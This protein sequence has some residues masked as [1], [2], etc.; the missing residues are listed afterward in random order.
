MHFAELTAIITALLMTHT[1]QGDGIPEP[2]L[3]M[4]GSVSNITGGNWVANQ[5][6][7]WQISF[8]KTNI[9]VTSKWVVVNSQPFYIAQVPFETRSI[10]GLTMTPNP[11]A[12]ELTVAASSYTRSPK[13]GTN[14]VQFANPAQTNFTF[15]SANRGSI[16]RIDLVTSI[17]STSETYE[18]WATRLFGRTDNRL[19]DPDRDGFSNYAEF[20]AGTDPQ[21]AES[22][23]EFINVKPIHG[24]GVT[25]EWSSVSNKR[26]SIERTDSLTKPFVALKTG[27]AS[28]PPANTYTDATATGTGP[29][30]YRLRLEE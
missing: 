21:N 15:S 11:N 28:T 5:P 22:V 12:F 20:K 14:M 2:G 29:Y 18:Q 25:I 8:G 7:I 10:P 6:L 30:I 1:V 3:A 19:E 13:M 24:G 16:E 26:Y 23:F 17:G 9:A 27:I 4:Y